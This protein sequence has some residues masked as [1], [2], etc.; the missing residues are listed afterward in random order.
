MLTLLIS[1]IIAAASSYAS[2]ANGLGRG[3]TISIGLAGFFVSMFLIGFI[4]RKKI[5]RAQSGL[6]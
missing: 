5:A 4:I 1:I 6:Q 2:Y 3:A